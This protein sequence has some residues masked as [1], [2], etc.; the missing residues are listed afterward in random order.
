[1]HHP[2]RSS[3][4]ARSGQ[5]LRTAWVVVQESNAIAALDIEAGEL[6]ELRDLGFKGHLLPGNMTITA[7]P[8]WW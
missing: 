1:M 5:N 6:T 3:V 7:T 8:C 2:F 4:W